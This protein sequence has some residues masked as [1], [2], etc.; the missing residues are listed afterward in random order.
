MSATPFADSGQALGSIFGPAGSL[1]GRGAG[2]ILGSLFGRGEYKLNSNSL[3]S[4]Q[5]P[6]FQPQK[7]PG[8]IVVSH[9]EFIQDITTPGAAFS[10]SAFPL[11]PGQSATF[12]WLSQMAAQFE[13]YEFLGLVFHFKT[14]SATAVSSTNTALG[15]VIMATDYDSLDSNF[16]SKQQ[17]EAYEFAGSSIPCAS[18]LHPVE[19]SPRQ[20]PTARAYVRVGAAAS[21]SDL[22]LYDLGNFQV[23]TQG[24]QAAATIGELWVSYEVRFFKPKISIPLG[25]NLN[26]ASY[27]FTSTSTVDSIATITANPGS[28]LNLVRTAANT[29]SIPIVGRYRVRWQGVA[30]TSI[31]T[32]GLM[33]AGT[34][35]TLISGGTAN[36]FGNGTTNYAVTGVFDITAPGGTVVIPAPTI[37][38][39][40]SSTLL[41]VDQIPSNITN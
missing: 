16:V 30:V 40:Q 18:F 22:R 11:N 13:E 7:S 14:T 10:I 19:C 8:E 29:F 21:A 4:N 25:A 2:S 5:T 3:L 20:N 32:G 6:V 31:T 27:S 33:A 12:P 37:V 34:N 36:Q 9:R 17:M 15:T 38:G 1:I 35:S 39:A 26:S 24:Q 41:D 23:A 28:H